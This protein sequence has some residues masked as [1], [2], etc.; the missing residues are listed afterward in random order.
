MTLGER[1]SE[2]M[3][4][5][6][7]A[8]GQDEQSRVPPEAVPEAGLA[9]LLGATPGARLTVQLED[10]QYSETVRIPAPGSVVGEIFQDVEL[11][12]ASCSGEARV[13][14]LDAQRA[15]TSAEACDSAREALNSVLLTHFE[16]GK[17]DTPCERKQMFSPD[18]HTR[19]SLSCDEPNPLG[20]SELRLSATHEP[21]EEAVYSSMRGDFDVNLSTTE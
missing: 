4:S 13:V 3:A 6:M 11:E 10:V 5:T 12:L 20:I 7:I 19:L 1:M 21:T 15:F 17:G 2:I 14:S 8:P 16:S 18:G 9:E